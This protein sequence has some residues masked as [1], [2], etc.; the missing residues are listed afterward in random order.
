MGIRLKVRM[1]VFYILIVAV[2]VII[3]LLITNTYIFNQ[4]SKIEEKDT[5]DR[6]KIIINYL[7]KDLDELVSLSI[8]WGAWDA[9]YQ[10][11]DDLNDTY[12]QENLVDRTF[13]D[14]RWNFFALIRSDGEIAYQKSYQIEG[15]KDTELPEE[16]HHFLKRQDQITQLT[17]QGVAG[18][19]PADGHYFLVSSYPVL[20]STLEGEPKGA[21]LVGRLIDEAW[22]NRFIGD[23]QM[24]V[25]LIDI[26][27][28]YIEEILF[29]DVPLQSHES[30]Y[31]G[32]TYFTQQNSFEQELS[33]GYIFFKSMEGH[34]AFALKFHKNMDFYQK[35]KDSS[36][37]FLLILGFII[38]VTFLYSWI[39]LNK[40]ILRRLNS[41]K[42][43]IEEMEKLKDFSK[44]LP[45][46]EQRDEI[47]FLE[48]EF[49]KLIA[50]VNK[51]YHAL[52]HKAHH[53]PL[54]GLPN[55]E[56][57]YEQVES[58]IQ[59][60][61][62]YRLSAVFYIDLDGFKAVNDTYGHHIGDELLKII[63]QKFST[64]NREDVIVSRIGGDE[65]LLFLP[66]IDTKQEAEKFAEIL[67]QQLKDCKSIQ[68][69]PIEL[70]A[71][72][73]ISFYPEH[74]TDLKALIKFADESM[75]TVKRKHK[76]GFHTYFAS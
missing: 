72:I 39:F 35:G 65:F 41:I 4:Y 31:L 3:Q 2:V 50:S 8:D 66:N 7:S 51:S 57:F 52:K 54:T 45:L 5:A 48:N 64:I 34:D 22:L 63:S 28:P 61:Y 62:G 20:T 46:S 29:G 11:I 24:Q 25:E 32:T 26:Q 42:E 71:S 30:R 9:T 21:L 56:H 73:G 59:T 6:I 44:V 58:L 10:F 70:S 43:Q 68:N 16:L 75:Y 27:D 12:I 76:N 14:N 15:I 55:R 49:N 17:Q 40:H 1:T 33:T 18:I 38:G 53:D 69:F 60:K 19:L 67:I 74:S 47:T 37:Y 13:L 23:I 36:L